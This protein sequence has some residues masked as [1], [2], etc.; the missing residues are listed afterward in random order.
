SLR[1]SGRGASRTI[2]SAP[3]TISRTRSAPSVGDTAYLLNPGRSDAMQNV[4][5]ID[6]RSRRQRE[7]HA[8]ALSK[9]P[10]GSISRGALANSARIVVGADDYMRRL[11]RQDQ[12]ADATSRE[13]GPPWHRAC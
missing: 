12:R 13:C 2:S 7:L 1:I 8:P 9:P 5:K 11:A 3:S 6:T 10:R 4:V